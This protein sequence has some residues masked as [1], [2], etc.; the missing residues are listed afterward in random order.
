MTPTATAKPTPA[1]KSGIESVAVSNLQ[2]QTVEQLRL[3]PARWG[4]TVNT[5]LLYQAVRMYRANLRAGTAATKTRGEVSG[6][7]KKPWKQKHTGRARAGSNRSPLWRHGGI[8]FGPHPRDFSYRLP[9]RIRRQALAESL[10]AKL[11][12]HEIIVVDELTAQTPKTKPFAGLLQQ[13]GIVKSSL[14]VLA[15]LDAPTVLSLRNLEHVSLRRAQDLTAFDVLNHDKLVMTKAAWA[16]VERRLFGAGA[17]QPDA[18][19]AAAAATT[20]TRRTPAPRT[21]DVPRA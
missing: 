12:D 14:I 3:D 17:S 18:A 7:G 20:A 4:G 5:A 15:A 11:R 13:F 9:E 8:V 6:G 16:A 10:A 1:K 2:G 21:K 19:P